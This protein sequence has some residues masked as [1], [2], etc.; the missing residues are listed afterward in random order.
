MNRGIETKLLWLL[1]GGGYDLEEQG[2][3]TYDMDLVNKKVHPERC[4]EFCK[5]HNINDSYCST[6]EDYARLLTNLGIV[7]V[8]NS[9]VTIAGEYICSIFLPE[10]MTLSQ[11]TFLED[12]KDLFQE[13]YY[14][15]KSFFSPRVYTNFPKEYSYKITNH[16]RDLYIESIIANNPCKNGQQLLYQELE[17]QK[18]IIKA[19]KN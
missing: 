19:R 11:I 14:E 12:L 6:H 13:K 4:K 17:R 3:I 5:E 8:Y 10:E 15:D 1:P 18:E 7:V 2:A 16:F 9:A